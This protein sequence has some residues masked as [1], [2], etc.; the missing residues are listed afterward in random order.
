MSPSTVDRYL[1]VAAKYNMLHNELDGEF[2]NR[3]FKGVQLALEHAVLCTAQVWNGQA[4]SIRLRGYVQSLV[5]QMS[6]TINWE[7]VSRTIT[8]RGRRSHSSGSR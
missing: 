5:T 3:D 1:R 8:S 7:G 4:P 2:S 6:F